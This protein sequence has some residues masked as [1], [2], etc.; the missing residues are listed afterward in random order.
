MNVAALYRVGPE[1][2]AKLTRSSLGLT[3]TA[4]ASPQ[5]LISLECSFRL[6]LFG[7]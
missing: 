3:Q 7:R 4:V 1:M 5:F 2:E 6:R